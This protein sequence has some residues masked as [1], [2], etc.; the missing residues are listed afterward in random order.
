ML[1]LVSAGMHGNVRAAGRAVVQGAS[2]A[3]KAF[4]PPYAMAAR[5]MENKSCS[6]LAGLRDQQVLDAKTPSPAA[7]RYEAQAA[8][9][10]RAAADARARKGNRGFEENVYN[11]LTK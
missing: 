5:A 2:A 3:A 8:R 11:R 6:A 7:I 10:K 9:I 1:L 4:V